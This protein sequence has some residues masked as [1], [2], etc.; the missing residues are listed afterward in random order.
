M[1]SPLATLA[2]FAAGVALVAATIVAQRASRR[3]LDRGPLRGHPRRA[4]AASIWIGLL[5]GIAVAVAAAH[6]A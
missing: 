2:L 5:A 3:L 6:L 1:S 4:A